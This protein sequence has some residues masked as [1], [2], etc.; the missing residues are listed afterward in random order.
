MW[1]GQVILRLVL[2][3]V[4]MVKLILFISIMKKWL[5][6]MSFDLFPDLILFGISELVVMMLSFQLWCFESRRCE[7]NF[8]KL[9]KSSKGRMFRWKMLA[10]FWCRTGNERIYTPKSEGVK[11][12]IP[13]YPQ[14]S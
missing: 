14:M 10:D 2:M 7:W 6:N 11:D 13:D 4:M 3:L 5:V 1:I 8:L 9:M 12:D